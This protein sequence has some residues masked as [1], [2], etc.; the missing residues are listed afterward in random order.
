[1]QRSGADPGMVHLVHVH[2]PTQWAC[3]EKFSRVWSVTRL[4]SIMEKRQGSL[5]DFGVKRLRSEGGE[6]LETPTGN[7][8]RETSAAV[9]SETPGPCG[10]VGELG[11]G[12]LNRPYDVGL[13][14]LT[15]ARALSSSDRYLRKCSLR[16][17]RLIDINLFQV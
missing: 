3:L 2:P 6:I 1:M 7:P 16:Q 13:V 5:T 4:H 15:F 14:G 10:A 9:V 11:L 8:K 12:C 17:V